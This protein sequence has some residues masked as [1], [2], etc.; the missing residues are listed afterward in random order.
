MNFSAPIYRPGI[1]GERLEQG[2]AAAPYKGGI[3]TAIVAAQNSVFIPSP[4]F[5]GALRPTDDLTTGRPS[6]QT[7]P[8]YPAF[9]LPRRM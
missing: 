6:P 4:I 3:A 5:Y 7:A 1:I 8:R 2:R 9:R